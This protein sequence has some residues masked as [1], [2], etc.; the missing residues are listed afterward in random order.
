MLQSLLTRSRIKGAKRFFFIFYFLVTRCTLN[1][2]IFFFFKY[3]YPVTDKSNKIAG[4][5]ILQKKKKI[6]ARVRIRF[7]S[8]TSAEI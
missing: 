2:K 1:L 5:V 7:P 3:I 6:L 4:K 8:I